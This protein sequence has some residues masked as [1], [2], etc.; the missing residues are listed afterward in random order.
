MNNCYENDFAIKKNLKTKKSFFI[1]TKNI[2][3][4]HYNL[5]IQK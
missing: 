1:T 5:F 2:N 3:L 4:L